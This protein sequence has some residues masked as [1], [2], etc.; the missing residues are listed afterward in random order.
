MFCFLPVALAKSGVM[1]IFC[2]WIGLFLLHN[3]ARPLR[4]EAFSLVDPTVTLKGEFL[5]L[6]CQ[7]S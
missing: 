5:L 2:T 7:F 4:I 1:H 6:S 3:F